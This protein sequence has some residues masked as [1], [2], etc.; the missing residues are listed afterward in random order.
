M[1]P[2]A[3]SNR[4]LPRGARFVMM[5]LGSS[6]DEEVCRLDHMM[7][8]DEWRWF[9]GLVYDVGHRGDRISKVVT[10]AL[11]RGKAHKNFAMS[12]LGM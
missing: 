9:V 2:I 8:E 12:A 10:S 3:Y 6:L 1:K 11:R 4:R 5:E 7:V